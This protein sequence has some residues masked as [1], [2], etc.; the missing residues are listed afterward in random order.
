MLRVIFALNTYHEMHAVQ[1]PLFFHRKI[2]HS[3]GCR[4]HFLIIMDF[5]FTLKCEPGMSLA[6][7][8]K[9]HVARQRDRKKETTSRY[10]LKL[11]MGYESGI[12]YKVTLSQHDSFICNEKLENFLAIQLRFLSLFLSLSVSA[13]VFVDIFSLIGLRWSLSWSTSVWFAK[14]NS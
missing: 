3:F 2:S 10:K 8:F 12:D 1:T 4:C 7:I 14:E 6:H 5:H 13:S 11:T 9:R